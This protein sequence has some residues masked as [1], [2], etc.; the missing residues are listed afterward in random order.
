M[1]I[2]TG[3]ERE[4]ERERENV[5]GKR[6][7]Q[8]KGKGENKRPV[9]LV[10]AIQFWFNV[11]LYR[12]FAFMCQACARSGV[13]A[14]ALYKMNAFFFYMDAGIWFLTDWNSQGHIFCI[15]TRPQEKQ[16]NNKNYNNNNKNN[17]KNNKNPKKRKRSKKMSRKKTTID[18]KFV[19]KWINCYPNVG[20]TCD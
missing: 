19:L 13:H 11:I 1:H 6:E 8:L 20:M 2:Y 5:K 12:S 3:R 15:I 7:R 4:R 14:S 17:N 16:T 18:F 10:V 9:R